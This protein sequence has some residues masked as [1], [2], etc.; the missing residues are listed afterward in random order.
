MGNSGVWSGFVPGLSEGVTYKYHITSRYGGYEVDKAD[1]YGV[2]HE[3]APK[4]ASL[5]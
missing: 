3:T 2:R 1:P 4:T 5:V